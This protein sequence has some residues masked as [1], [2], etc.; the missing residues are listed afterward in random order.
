M[1]ASNCAVGLSAEW[2][3]HIFFSKSGTTWVIGNY[4]GFRGMTPQSQHAKHKVRVS[5][6]RKENTTIKR[7]WV[8]LGV[9]LD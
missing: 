7:K 3:S 6:K 4:Q 2:P 5:N 1:S 8:K 9:R